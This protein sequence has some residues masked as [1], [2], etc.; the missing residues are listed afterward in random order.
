MNLLATFN[1]VEKEYVLFI[2]RGKI[3]YGYYDEE[4]IKEDLTNEERSLCDKVRYGILVSSDRKNHIKCGKIDY[5]NKTFQI[6]YDKVSKK[7]FFL[8]FNGEKYIKPTESEYLYLDGFLNPITYNSSV[9]L[10][11]VFVKIGGGVLTVVLVLSVY[12]SYLQAVSNGLDLEFT[13]SIVLSDDYS[14]RKVFNIDELVLLVNKNS[15][16]T[17]EEKKFLCDEIGKLREVSSSI[18]ASY[19]YDRLGD[20]DIEYIDFVNAETIISST[21]VLY[22]SGAYNPQENVITLVGTNIDDCNSREHE[23]RH[24]FF[25]PEMHSLGNS[26]QEA[27]VTIFDLESN[28]GDLS[29]DKGSYKYER[30]MV[31]LLIELLGANVFEEYHYGGGDINVIIDALLQIIND[32]EKAMAIIGEVDN[33]RAKISIEVDKEGGFFY[34]ELVGEAMAEF[35]ALYFEYWI[36]KFE[37]PLNPYDAAGI[38]ML[39]YSSDNINVDG[40]LKKLHEQAW[41]SIH[42]YGSN[43][44]MSNPRFGIIPKKYFWLDSHENSFVYVFMDYQM[45][46]ENYVVDD[47]YYFLSD[48]FQK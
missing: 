45:E 32:E 19:M 31:Y 11:K 13:D 12:L 35:N 18:N 20:V 17:E 44:A 46:G 40:P 42:E 47:F 26:I 28:D 27:V 25:S 1:S 39:F 30:N 21:G 38:Y 41:K 43:S 5:N 29:L 9:N 7:K 8:E 34:D 24:C 23:I 48:T 3:C 22:K 16:L 2:R 36:A 10:K 6:I 4:N 14:N 33:I 15:K 37:R